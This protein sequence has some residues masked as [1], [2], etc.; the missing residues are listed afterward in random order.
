MDLY[1]LVENSNGF[2]RPLRMGTA[3]ELSVDRERLTQGNSLG[4]ERMPGGQTVGYY[5]VPKGEWD[6]Q[7]CP[8]IP[9]DFS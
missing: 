6:S 2:E 1:Y 5:L 8:L 4:V 9:V 3:E 7:H